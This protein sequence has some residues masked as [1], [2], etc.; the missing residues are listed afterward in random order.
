M[1]TGPK[2]EKRPADPIARVLKVTRVTREKLKEYRPESDKDT[3]ELGRKGG[4]K[5][6][7]ARLTDSLV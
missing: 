3:Q 6:A 7:D 1:P 5:R 2:D 4:R